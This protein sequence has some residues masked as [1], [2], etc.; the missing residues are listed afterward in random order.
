[1]Q[2]TSLPFDG[3]RTNAAHYFGRRGVVGLLTV[4]LG[5]CLI[6]PVGGSIAWGDLGVLAALAVATF[7]GANE[8]RR[9]VRQ[10][11]IAPAAEES[12]A[13]TPWMSVIFEASGPADTAG[14]MVIPKAPPRNDPER[15]SLVR[16]AKERRH[17]AAS[18]R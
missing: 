18:R 3:E 1:V 11:Q 13:E 15:R 9:L 6:R 12:L 5:I 4:G 16:R 8:A 17:E 14:S 7:L 10:Q 2:I